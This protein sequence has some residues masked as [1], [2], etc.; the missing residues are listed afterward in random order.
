FR[1]STLPLQMPD[2][3]EQHVI[4]HRKIVQSV[5]RAD[6]PFEAAQR[7]YDPKQAWKAHPQPLVT[8]LTDL[9]NCFVEVGGHPQL[10]LWHWWLGCVQLERGQWTEAVTYF[11][12]WLDSGSQATVA[13]A[14]LGAL[15]ASRLLPPL[16]AVPATTP[17][18]MTT[19][20]PTT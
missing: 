5:D 14:A 20:T 7:F 15:V 16:P 1:S 8:L 12:A 17:T 19:T 6:W 4:V 2:D 3:A 9:L 10:P 18:T 11:R 13:S